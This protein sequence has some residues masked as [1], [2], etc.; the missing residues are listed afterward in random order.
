MS[1]LLLVK[2]CDEKTVSSTWSRL[3]H[4]L[5]WAVDTP[6]SSGSE[7]MPTFP[8]T[9]EALKNKKGEFALAAASYTA[10]C[11]TVRAFYTWAKSHYSREYRNIDL[12]WI[13]TIRPPRSRSEQSQIKERE[14]YSLDEVIKLV[15]FPAEKPQLRRMQAAAALLFLSGMRVGALVSLP[16]DCV[17]LENLRVYQL[18]EKG[19]NTKNHKAGITSLLNIPILL[20]VCRAWKSHLEENAFPGCLYFAAFAEVG[21]HSKFAKE[22]PPLK[23]IK[24]LNKPFSKFLRE[25]CSIAEIPYRSAHKFRHGHAV[26]SLKKAQN[27]E[28]LKAISLN[29][30]HSSIGITDGIYGNLA[31]D[32]VHDVITSLP[33]W[34]RITRMTKRQSKEY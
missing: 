27:M 32:N 25:L 34:S 10:T 23:T 14:R 29:L 6:F 21:A 20:D 4:V 13:L 30:M 16:A 33:R 19:V 7:I 15:T 28:Q 11:K 3:R 8:A 5:E 24:D 31:N 17:D 12:A 26:Y 9:W 1:F 22:N 18:P 2:Q